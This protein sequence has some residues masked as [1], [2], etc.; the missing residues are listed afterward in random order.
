MLNKKIALSL[1][2]IALFATGCV[3]EKFQFEKEIGK[4]GTGEGEFLN[5]TDLELTLDGNL[6]I[7]DAGNTRFKV[8]T[9]DGRL[10][11]EAG[12]RGH[13]NYRL[14]TISGIGVN[15]LTGD[16]WACDQRG[17]KIVRFDPDGRP[18]LRITEKL[19]FPMDIALDRKGY[20]YVI[21]SRNPQIN[22]YNADGRFV[23][24]IGGSGKAAF[25]FPTTITF[26]QDHLFITDFGG[27]RIVK[28]DTEGN[29]VREYTQKGEFEEMKGPSGMHLDSEG[30]MYILDLGEVPVVL[31]NKEGELISKIGDF[32]NEP[33][34]FLYPTG[35]VAK[36]EDEIFVLDNSRNTILQF[37]RKPE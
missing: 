31:L 18:N 30:N 27:K 21:M 32:G 24:T 1:L 11:F 33:G 20:A 26:H 15:P 17:S 25:I 13:E 34:R 22:K 35:V 14:A 12:N 5:A 10:K 37:K 7:S 29:F 19:R 36:S 3:P 4:A 16:I 28:L 8:I 9:P 23:S 2:I 6:V